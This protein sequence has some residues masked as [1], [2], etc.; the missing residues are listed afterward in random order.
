M[1]G[2]PW[3]ALGS[4]ASGAGSLYLLAQLRTHWTKPGA[5]WFVATIGT[6]TVWSV[7]YGVALLISAPGTRL[8]LAPVTWLCLSWLGLFFAAF[9]LGYT[10]RRAFLDGALFRSFAIVP[11]AV[12]ALAL[13][14]GRHELLWADARVATNGALSVVEYTIQPLGYFAV[15]LTMVF[16]VF[17]TMLVFD[18]V[19][20]YG[21]LYRREAVAVGLSPLPPGLAMLAWSLG[22]GPGVN[23]TTVA[24]LP[25]LALDA[26]AFV[27]SDMFEF[28]PATRR[29]GERAAIDDIATPVV[30][31]DVAGRVYTRVDAAY[32]AQGRHLRG[33]RDALSVVG[34]VQRLDAVRVAGEE[35][36]LLRSVPERKGVHPP[37]VLDH[38]PS[39]LGVE[40]QQH[41]RVGVRRKLIPFCLE[42]SSKPLIVVDFSVVAHDER[43]VVSVHRLRAPLR[44]IEDRQPPVGQP[45]V[46]SVADPQ[47]VG[48]RASL[49]HAVAE[50]T[51][52]V[53]VDRPT[54]VVVECRGNP[55][56]KSSEL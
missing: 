27:R 6:I 3:I 48:V 47:P 41:L 52:P 37:Q 34:H 17:G 24:F 12:S 55:T 5:K 26:Y 16:V 14:N 13:T 4:F 19:L 56:H 9:A 1:A 53:L 28:H 36:P 15:F 25:H 10:G 33:H 30:I 45:D 18:T 2:V 29:A 23:L 54:V 8:A 20:S 50:L 31:V 22:F 32:R 51:E 46:S 40:V 7:G 49:R 44:K 11:V 38:V 35:E 43:P 39:V 42:L 21:P